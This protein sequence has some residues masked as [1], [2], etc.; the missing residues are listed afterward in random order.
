[1]V[2]MRRVLRVRTAVIAALL[3]AAAARPAWADALPPTLILSPG[4]GPASSTI[5]MTFDFLFVLLCP[6][7]QTVTFSWDGARTVATAQ[8][9]GAT[10]SA[11]APAAPPSDAS[12]PGPH[13]VSA[14]SGSQVASATFTILAAP[15]PSPSG[16]T[17]TPTPRRTAAPTPRQTPGRSPTPAATP[18]PTPTPPPTPPLPCDTGVPQATGAAAF[19][20]LPGVAGTATEPQHAGAIVV[21]AVQPRSMLPPAVGTVSLTAVEL[22]RPVDGSSP[23]LAR[24]VAGGARFDCAQLEIGPS[25]GYLYATYAFHGANLS[26]STPTGGA[27]PGTERLRLSYASVSWEYQLGDGSPI[28]TGSGQLGSAPDPR[29]PVR[30]GSSAPVPLLLAGAALLGGGLG[31]ALWYVTWARRRGNRGATSR[32]L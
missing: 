7:G 29:P 24:A 15:A 6:A 28:A 12:A 10:C 11:S 16:A 14:T 17:P 21:M 2:G 9:D 25:A 18:Q 27:Q 19:L 3:C 31:G 26:A 4:Q 5:T 32:H 1:M 30:T 23:A 22:V 8:L 13:T 20:E